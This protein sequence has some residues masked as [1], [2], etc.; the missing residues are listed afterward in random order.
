MGVWLKG[1]VLPG[2]D[3]G[4]AEID[5]FDDTVMVEKDV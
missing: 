1:L 2:D 5:V 3:L 4:G